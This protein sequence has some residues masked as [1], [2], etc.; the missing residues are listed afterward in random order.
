MSMWTPRVEEEPYSIPDGRLPSREHLTRLERQKMNQ[1]YAVRM[2]PGQKANFDMV[3]DVPEGS[4]IIKMEKD[5]RS[6]KVIFTVLV[7]VGEPS[8]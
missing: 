3:V 7:P 1:R 4:Q 5:N 6:E 8:W 2:I